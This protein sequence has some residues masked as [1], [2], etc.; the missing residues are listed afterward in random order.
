LQQFKQILEEEILPN[1]RKPLRYL[2]NEYNVVKKDWKA[3]KLRSLFAFPD[4]YEV[5]MSHLGL[6]ILYGL[7]N[8]EAD[9]LMERVFA[10]WSDMEN[11]LR[12][13]GLPLYSLESLRPIADF[14][15]IGFTLQY[16]MSYTNILNMLDLGKIPLRAEERGNDFPLIIAGGPCAYNPEPLAPFIDLFVLGEGE[17]VILEIYAVMAKH[18]AIR[19]GKQDKDELLRELTQIRG[20]YVPKFYEDLYDQKGKFLGVKVKE[21]GAAPYIV[22]RVVKDLDQAYFPLHP[23]VP[24]LEVVHDRMMLEVL[25][26]CSRGCRFCQAGF[27]YRP[28]R[29]RSKELLLQQA[30]KLSENTGHNEIS[31]T[32]LSTSD[33]TCVEPLLRESVDRF[34]K[35]RI[36]VSLPS[37][38]VDSFS[39]NLAKE[40][41]RVR[42]TGLTF[43]PE[44]GTQRLRDVINKNV[45]EEN[46]MEVTEA[47]FREGWTQLKLYFML[48]LPT[49]T[50]EDL[51]GIAAL[52][53]KVMQRAQEILREIGSR[54]RPKITVSV[55]SFVP[56]PQTPFQWEPQDSMEV[57]QEKQKYLGNR[58]KDKRLNYNYH[59]SKLSFLEAVFAKGDRRLG[60]VLWEAWHLGCRFDGWSEHFRYDLWREAFAKTGVVPEEIA[61]KPLTYEDALPWDHLKTGV[62]KEYLW[63]EKE[64][65]YAL[66]TTG[67]CRFATCSVCG[68]CQSLDVA[69]SLKKGE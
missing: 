22:K 57:L 23:I 49:E 7:V 44:A 51:D 35:K 55:S 24:Y 1:V 53:S 61:N 25:R 29:E 26:G 32:S 17:E 28:V 45:T 43:A 30:E 62:K 18:R 20:V 10:P 64:K 60:A 21:S 59:E 58:I 34:Q 42:K 13:R 52:A 63:Q 50:F 11:E 27:L 46:L 15:C 65:A 54:Q 3:V 6:Q 69:T 33:Y 12:T 31:L 66:A 41:Q 5:G 36:G 68:I 16:E 67:D 47:V 40:V 37:L 9:Y 19:Q 56:K 4:V 14:D 38:R 48:G 39:V 2:G 8:E